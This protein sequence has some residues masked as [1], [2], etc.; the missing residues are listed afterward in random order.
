MFY[1][2]AKQVKEAQNVQPEM[3]VV[4]SAELEHFIHENLT[5]KT[6]LVFSVLPAKNAYLISNDKD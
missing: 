5:D 3:F 1:L 2:V 4:E 6:V